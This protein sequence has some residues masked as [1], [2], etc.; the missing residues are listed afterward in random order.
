[1]DDWLSLS[2]ESDLLVWSLLGCESIMVLLELDDDLIGEIASSFRM[3][4]VCFPPIV[5]VLTFALS[6]GESE[7]ERINDADFDSSPL[8]D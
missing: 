1:M 4:F 6:D 5:V 2:V 8:V 3:I 7:Y